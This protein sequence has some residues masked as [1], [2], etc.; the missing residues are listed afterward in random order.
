MRISIWMLICK[1]N[2]YT[3][4]DN[5]LQINA[6]KANFSG[7]VQ[8]VDSS[9]IDMDVKLNTPKIDFKEILSLIPS[10][11]ANDFSSIKTSGKVALQA[12]AKGRMQGENLPALML[13]C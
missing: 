2:K 5:S 8:K 6:I 4:T 12:W 9:T 10:I 1:K 13:S 11:Y 3:F 7:F